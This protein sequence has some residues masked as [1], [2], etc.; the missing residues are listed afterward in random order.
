MCATPVICLP[1]L[2][3]YLKL[4]MSPLYP[5][6]SQHPLGLPWRRECFI[7]GNMMTTS[8]SAASGRNPVLVIYPE[9]SHPLSC[10]IYFL[11]FIHL[12]LY[13]LPDHI[14]ENEHEDDTYLL[15]FDTWNCE[16]NIQDTNTHSK[17]VWY[18][19]KST[20]IKT[21]S[22]CIIVIKELSLVKV[23]SH[24]PVSVW[25]Y[26]TIFCLSSNVSWSA[27]SPVRI[28]PIV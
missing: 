17:P 4:R 12:H 13:T 9:P 27:W 28:F 22:I 25:Q 20:I 2:V 3:A 5:H 16:S 6:Q 23:P 26:K 8:L 7:W 1:C 10:K 24:I 15:H 19:D 18:K 21:M 14:H 11:K